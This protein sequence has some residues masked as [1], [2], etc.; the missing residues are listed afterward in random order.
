[1]L[2]HPTTPEQIDTW[3]AAQSETEHLEFKEAKNQFDFDRLLKYCVAL[4]NERGGKLLLGIQ[5]KPPR[6]IVG[7][8]A[9]P[10]PAKTANDLF[11]KLHFRVDVEEVLHPNGRVVIFHVPSR[12]IGHP[13]EIDGSYWMRSGESLVA[14]SGDQLKQIIAEDKPPRSLTAALLIGVLIMSVLAAIGLA[15]WRAE[16]P[17]GMNEKLSS[18]DKLAAVVRRDSR[19]K[20]NWRD[21]LKVGM[22]KAEV[23]QLFGEA[24]KIDVSSNLEQWE[25]G[26]GQITFVDGRILSWLEPNNR[27]TTSKPN[28]ETPK[29]DDNAAGKKPSSPTVVQAPYGNLAERCQDLGIAILRFALGRKQ[30]QPDAK[31]HRQDYLDWFT[32]NDGGFRAFYYDD[33]KTL[34]KDLAADSFKDTHLDE[35]IARHQQYFI[36]RNQRPPQT[37]IDDAPMYH[38]S[39]ENIDE[40]GT[41]F[42]DLSVQIPQPVTAPRLSLQGQN[43]VAEINKLV[44]PYDRDMSNSGL[45]ETDAETERMQLHRNFMGNYYDNAFAFRERALKKLGRAT[46]DLPATLTYQAEKIIDDMAGGPN[47]KRYLATRKSI[48]IICQELQNLIDQLKAIGE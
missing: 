43:L 40:I 30:I 6:A 44:G 31:S 11:S 4:A 18:G 8:V 26:S 29:R 7:T 17:H 23:Q 2:L 39:I 25:Y 28:T 3:R 20:Q 15:I 1:M 38:L 46:G 35:L 32:R 21:Y 33:A 37:V 42:R 13:Y 14:M 47:P 5:D 24:E 9:F 10:N 19:N 34:Q 41:R 48:H 16:Q 27:E 22:T 36:E 12:P 45:T